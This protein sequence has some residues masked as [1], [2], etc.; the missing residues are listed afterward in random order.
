[1]TDEERQ[2]ANLSDAG[3]NSMAISVCSPW[4]ATFV[5]YD[6]QVYLKKVRCPVLALNGEKDLQV[7]CSENLNAIENALKNGKCRD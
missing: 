7:P 2:E 5:K 3:I 1:M 4:F 6:P